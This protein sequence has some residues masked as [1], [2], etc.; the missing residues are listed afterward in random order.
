MKMSFLNNLPGVQRH[1]EGQTE[2]PSHVREQAVSTMALAPFCFAPQPLVCCNAISKL[3]LS[4]PYSNFYGCNDWAYSERYP[5]LGPVL[6][7][8]TSASLC[9]TYVP[10][11]DKTER[12]LSYE[13]SN[14]AQEIEGMEPEGTR[15][16][17]I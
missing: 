3:P 12:L 2:H 16:Q 17:L 13:T 14:P 11:S 4:I 10:P 5:R 7:I 6:P 1:K 9:K 15:L 8:S